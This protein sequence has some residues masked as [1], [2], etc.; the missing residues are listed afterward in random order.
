VF[1]A[2]ILLS[3]KPDH[4]TNKGQKMNIVWETVKQDAKAELDRIWVIMTEASKAHED[5]KGTMIEELTFKTAKDYFQFYE[6]TKAAYK[7]IGLK[8][9]IGIHNI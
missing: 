3:G 9:S 8:G 6:T 2:I 5:A 4:R 1:C 7:A